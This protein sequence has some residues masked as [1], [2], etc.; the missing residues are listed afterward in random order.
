VSISDGAINDGDEVLA[1]SADEPTGW[2]FVLRQVNTASGADC[3]GCR[4]LPAQIF[5]VGFVYRLVNTISWRVT[6]A[7]PVFE[8]AV[9]LVIRYL[10]GDNDGSDSAIICGAFEPSLLPASIVVYPRQHTHLSDLLDSRSNP[11]LDLVTLNINSTLLI[12]KYLIKNIK[13]TFSH[14]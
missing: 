10:G 5:E 4:P 12:V 13:E 7:H 6:R 9:D 1:Q 2:Q 14:W 11:T 8:V 3:H